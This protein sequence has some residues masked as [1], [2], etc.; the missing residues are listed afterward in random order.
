MYE[1]VEF[2]FG[3]H[4]GGLSIRQAVDVA[5]LADAIYQKA[6]DVGNP[7]YGTLD[8]ALNDLGLRDEFL[9]VEPEAAE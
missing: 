6:M 8:R 3:E 7:T 2:W 1:R 9:C 4:T 5:E